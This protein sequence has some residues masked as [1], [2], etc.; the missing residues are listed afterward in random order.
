M[1]SQRAGNRTSQSFR[2]PHPVTPRFC[3]L[4]GPR[5]RSGFLFVTVTIEVSSEY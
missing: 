2:F 5:K 1:L 3:L 4:D